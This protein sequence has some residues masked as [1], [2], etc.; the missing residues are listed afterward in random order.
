[1]NSQRSEQCSER[2]TSLSINIPIENHQLL[3][4]LIRYI[5]SNSSHIEYYFHTIWNTRVLSLFVFFDDIDRTCCVSNFLN[6]KTDGEIRKYRNNVRTINLNIW[7]E[8]NMELFMTGLKSNNI[9]NIID[10]ININNRKNWT[11]CW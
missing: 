6:G 3:S 8:W 2:A 7:C 10:K 4:I 1:M 11:W 9:I 5:R